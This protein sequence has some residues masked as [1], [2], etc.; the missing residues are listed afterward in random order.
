M[1]SIDFN[2]FLIGVGGIIYPPDIL[3]I[4]E[5]HLDIIKEF[6]IG[7]DFVLKHLE[8]QKGI[9][10]RLIQNNH[11]QGLYMKN[12]SFHRPLYDIN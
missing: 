5:K 10:Q 11:P 3:N 8:I 2:I 1:K 7:D 6:I 9:E 12:N 4:N